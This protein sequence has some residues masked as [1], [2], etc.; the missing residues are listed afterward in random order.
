MILYKGIYN[1]LEKV[2]IRD[3]YDIADN[4][5]KT[6]KGT[7]LERLEKVNEMF[8]GHKFIWSEQK[9]KLVAEQK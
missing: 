7:T 9:I 2:N 5:M 8:V 3:A 4:I 6:V 1:E